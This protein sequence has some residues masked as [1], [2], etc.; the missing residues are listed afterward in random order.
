MVI[1]EVYY[2]IG[3]YVEF[4][5]RQKSL[6]VP[7]ERAYKTFLHLLVS[8]NRKSKDVDALFRL[9][10]LK[11]IKTEKKYKEI[12][13]VRQVLIDYT[14][15][16]KLVLTAL[17]D[18][19]EALGCVYTQAAG[20][21]LMHKILEGGRVQNIKL[22]IVCI[23]LLCLRELPRDEIKSLIKET[24]KVNKLSE[25]L[26]SRELKDFPW[27][28]FDTKTTIGKQAE[29]VFAELFPKVKVFDM[30]KHFEIDFIDRDFIISPKLNGDLFTCFDS[31][32]WT[33]YRNK[34]SSIPDINK[35]SSIQPKI[36]Q[37][38]TNVMSKL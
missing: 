16:P 26:K 25:K 32:W 20:V 31:V 15:N 11:A 2:M 23:I 28:A 33:Y 13:I 3:E 6:N 29:K 5:E 10:E 38:I 18:Q 12:H 35:W 7:E 4:M 19:I 14:L 21:F 37:E 9:S 8:L 27:Y 34:R 36:K 30:C 22:M 17:Q 1:S 24:V